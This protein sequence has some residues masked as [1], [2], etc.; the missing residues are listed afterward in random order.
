MNGR[1]GLAAPLYEQH[2]T[3]DSMQSP[4][5]APSNGHSVSY[6]SSQHA[7]TEGYG[8]SSQHAPAPLQSQNNFVAEAPNDREIALAD[9]IPVY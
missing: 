9:S 3:K 1:S 7:P 8:F 2:N 5:S 4:S 6:S